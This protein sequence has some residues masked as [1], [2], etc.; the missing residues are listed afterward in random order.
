MAE[1]DELGDEV[2]VE[3]PKLPETEMLKRM[4]GRIELEEDMPGMKGFF[5]NTENFG[6]Y[7]VVEQQEADDDI[8]FSGKQTYPYILTNRQAQ[9]AF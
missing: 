4:V 9:Y 5:M 7:G 6:K 1:D 2:E 3:G 8:F